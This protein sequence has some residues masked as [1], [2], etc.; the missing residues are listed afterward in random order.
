MSAPD[1]K[2]TRVG[3]RDERYFEDRTGDPALCRFEACVAFTAEDGGQVVCSVALAREA[4]QGL[5]DREILGALRR[6]LREDMEKRAKWE[7]D[8]PGDWESVPLERR[9]ACALEALGYARLPC[10]LDH[11]PEYWRRVLDML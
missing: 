1:E 6:Q 7:V 3:K 4:S 10:P 2:G 11:A 8:A 9:R 5:T